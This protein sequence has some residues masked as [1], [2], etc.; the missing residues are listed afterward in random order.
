MTRNDITLSFI[1]IGSYAGIIDL[2]GYEPI[3]V[4][5]NDTIKK[6]AH[7]LNQRVTDKKKKRYGTF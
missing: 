4:S 1:K 5:Y 6:W 7:L 3:V 2:P